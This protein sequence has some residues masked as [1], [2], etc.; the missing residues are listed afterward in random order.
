MGR[1][2]CFW[3]FA[4]QRGTSERSGNGVHVSVVKA[5]TDSDGI[6]VE[7]AGMATEKKGT[8]N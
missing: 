6:T 2:R 1:A 8:E 3:S 4:W 5:P 7:K